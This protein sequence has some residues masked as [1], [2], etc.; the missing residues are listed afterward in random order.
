[1]KKLIVFSFLVFLTTIATIAQ[2]RNHQPRVRVNIQNNGEQK[3]SQPESQPTALFSDSL[4]T[5]EVNPSMVKD[6]PIEVIDSSPDKP[7]L[8]ESDT[9]FQRVLKSKK[10]PKEKNVP[11]ILKQNLPNT[12]Q[13]LIGRNVNRVE[14]KDF[15]WLLFLLITLISILV[16]GIIFF[17][18]SITT[19]VSVGLIEPFLA[20][21]IS[22]IVVGLVG[23]S[24]FY[25]FAAVCGSLG[26]CG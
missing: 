10:M 15:N 18:L 21:G 6:L 14:K 5:N 1:M 22:L 26:I 25:F 12:N 2:R 13:D 11:K 9:T 19:T 8:K 24:I 4:M 17:I 20:M 23:G 16:A 7:I 3:V